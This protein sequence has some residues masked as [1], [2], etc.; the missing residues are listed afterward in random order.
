MDMNAKAEQLTSRR[1]DHFNHRM[2]TAF[3]STISCTCSK[4]LS[5]RVAVYNQRI[6]AE[7]D[8]L[9]EEVC[10]RVQHSCYTPCGSCANA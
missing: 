5:Q 6:V 2:S 3:M 8:S 10:C 4:A 1:F 9:G 7:G